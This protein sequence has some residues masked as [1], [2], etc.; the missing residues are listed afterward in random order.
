MCVVFMYVSVC[1]STEIFK[2][3]YV[4]ACICEGKCTCVCVLKSSLITLLSFRQSLSLNPELTK[5]ANLT[6]QLAPEV[7]LTL[8]SK[9]LNYS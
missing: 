1:E 3:I 8:S 5:K 6:S 7:F 4:V 9:Q 2:H